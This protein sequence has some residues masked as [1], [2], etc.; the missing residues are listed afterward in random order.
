M[1]R[2][3]PC[4]Y[5]LWPGPL[6]WV[7]QQ[8]VQPRQRELLRCKATRSARQLQTWQLTAPALQSPQVAFPPKVPKSPLRV[9]K[10]GVADCKK[11]F[12]CYFPLSH[13]VALLDYPVFY[14]LLPIN[15]AQDSSHHQPGFH[16]V[17]PSCAAGPGAARVRW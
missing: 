14:S 12:F 11:G 10:V 7:I 13:T 1:P 8:A 17:L 6:P 4:V 15:P 16:A 5:G 2:W 3:D 9:V